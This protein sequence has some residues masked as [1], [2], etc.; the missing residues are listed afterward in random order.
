[1]HYP[2]LT[3]ARGLG[4]RTHGSVEDTKLSTNKQ[5]SLSLKVFINAGACLL[6]TLDVARVARA[7]LPY[8][9]NLVSGVLL[10][11][12]EGV[13]A[14][15]VPACGVRG[16][17]MGARRESGQRHECGGAVPGNAGGLCTLVGSA[18]QQRG[19]VETVC[20]RTR[21][22]LGDTVSS[23]CAGLG[24]RGRLGWCGGR[25]LFQDCCAGRRLG[26]DA[27]AAWGAGALRKGS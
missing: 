16:C 17:C 6:C 18:L 22:G 20:G 14:R 1:M 26:H 7:R 5:H 9:E 2:A 25:W 24:M 27:A 13:C 10:G 8:A 3:L 11:A 12:C 4:R 23:R 21:G 19:R 15:A